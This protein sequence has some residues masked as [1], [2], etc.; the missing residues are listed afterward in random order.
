MNCLASDEY[1]TIYIPFTAERDTEYRMYRLD[2]EINVFDLLDKAVIASHLVKYV[3][4]GGDK[5]SA[6]LAQGESGILWDM[7]V[8]GEF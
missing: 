6:S 5:V 1:L 3:S 4:G 7:A 2:L 8:D